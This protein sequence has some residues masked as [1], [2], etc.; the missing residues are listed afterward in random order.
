MACLP[1]WVHGDQSA[2]LNK[3]AI[4]QAPGKRTSKKS[5]ALRLASWNIRTMCPG[6]YND[7]PLTEDMRKTAIIDKE[8]SR[9][10]IDIACL[11]ETR[12]ADNGRISEA[13][14]TFLWQGLPSDRPRQHG[15]GFA[16][17]NSL[18]TYIEQVAHGTERIL[19]IKLLTSMGTAHILS[20]YAPTLCS[21]A[22]TKDHFYETWIR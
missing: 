15:V 22:E 13:N 1:H 3:R 17:K 9:L 20:L 19:G 4:S 12:L 2:Q 11:Q 21:E 6:I 18:M 10:N 8:L 7:L 5:P 14:Y 16:V